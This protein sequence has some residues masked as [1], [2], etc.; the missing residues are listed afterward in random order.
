MNGIKDTHD[1]R[2]Q[3]PIA[4]LGAG[5]AGL[6][7][8]RL[9][10]VKGIR[11]VVFERDANF[12]EGQQGG[13]LDVQAG[14]GQEV[15]KEGGLL[16]EF[17]R[18]ARYDGQEMRGAD[19]QGN[20]FWKIDY[21]GQEDRPEIGRKELRRML[22]ESVPEAKVRWGMKVDK[23][24][25]ESNGLMAVKFAGGKVESGF[26]LVVGAD[27][28]WSKAR[29][30]I[31]S[32]KPVYSGVLQL[33]FGVSPSNPI[34]DQVGQLC[35]KGSYVAMSLGNTIYIQQQ[36][37]KSYIVYIARHAP[38]NWRET[39][40]GKMALNDAEGYKTRLLDTDFANWNTALKDVIRHCEGFH[41]VWTL[42]AL[43]VEAMSWKSVP[44][45]TLIGDAA[46]LS[47]PSGAGGVNV[48]MHD[49][50]ELAREIVV[51]GIDNLNEAVRRYEETM[52]PRAREHIQGGNFIGSIMFAE[53]SPKGFQ[54]WVKSMK[55][56]EGR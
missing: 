41:R 40:E 3:P 53:D 38:E 29:S 15:L 25:R 18:L 14:S 6:S 20:I 46:H 11:F 12:S 34:H 10:E 56:G 13:T 23:V 16:E 4:I 5:P 32:T 28:A 48:G 43:P 21:E 22:M 49:A 36:T 2:E 27:G 39:E 44:G 7:L 1:L 55:F 8:A 51:S 30:L 54:E 37:D 26:K 47:L 52:L 31:H 24:E 9:L 42:Y 45:V 33:Q 17:K 50:L 35:R 19:G